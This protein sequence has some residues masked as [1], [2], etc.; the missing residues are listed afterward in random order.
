M[1]RMLQQ[2][3][4]DDYVLATGETRTVREFIEHAFAVVGR[5]I[6]WKGSARDEIGVDADSKEVL[7]EVDARYF[8]PTEVDTLLGDAT[9]ARERLGWQPRVSFKELV[10]EMMASDL[11]A[12]GRGPAR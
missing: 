3:K 4:P 1:W 2:A 6:E 9:K 5:R 10:A 11:K 7:I 8:R 12:G